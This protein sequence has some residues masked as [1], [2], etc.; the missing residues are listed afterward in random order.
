MQAFGEAFYGR[1]AAYDFAVTAGHG[2]LA[3]AFCK[4]ILASRN[5]EQAGL[6][7]SY[8]EAAITTLNGLDDAAFVGGAWKFPVPDQVG[9]VS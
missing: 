5:I 8:A 4:N 3:Q 2:A 6:L 1:T 9:T 7:A